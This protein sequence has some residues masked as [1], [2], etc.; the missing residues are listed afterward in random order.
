M[1]TEKNR[2][3]FNFQSYS[4]NHDTDV[5]VDINGDH[6]DDAKIKKLLS[7]FLKAIESNLTVS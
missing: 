4:D 2:I 5:C 6:V 1:N 3:S 7:T